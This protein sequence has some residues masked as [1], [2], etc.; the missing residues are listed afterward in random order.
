MSLFPLSPRFAKILIIGNQQDCLPYVIAIVSALSVGDPFISEAELSGNMSD[1]ARKEFR[2]KFNH[3]RALFGKLDPSSD[4]MM[5][6]SAVCAFD[7]VPQESQNEFLE[8][9]YLRHKMMEEIQKLRKQVGNIVENLV[10]AANGLQIKNEM[11]LPMPTKKQVSAMK[12]MIASGFIDQVAIRG[13]IISQEVKITN[14]SNIIQV[15]YCPV[16]PIDEDR[17]FTFIQIH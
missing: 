16:M 12:Q 15:P 7:H 14:K 3:S 9:H 1:E 10:M 13:D 11:K 8:G 4:C 2:S 17:L 6:L 5:L